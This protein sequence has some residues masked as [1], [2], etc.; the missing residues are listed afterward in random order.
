[1]SV[2]EWTSRSGDREI[3][4]CPLRRLKTKFRFPTSL[5]SMWKNMARPA[6]PHI[7]HPTVLHPVVLHLHS[8]S[9]ISAISEVPGNR[10]N[11]ING[12][13]CQTMISQSRSPMI[14]VISGDL[15]LKDERTTDFMIQCYIVRG[16]QESLTK[17]FEE[18]S[19]A[20]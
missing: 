6:L 1:M 7:R 14:S 3:S 4:N 20:L 15:N 8:I 11:I 17:E 16:A 12:S 5:S 13:W 2:Q 10:L 18:E 19:K 9:H